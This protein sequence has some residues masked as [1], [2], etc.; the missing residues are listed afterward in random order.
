MKRLAA[1]AAPLA[2]AVCGT[3]HAQ[4]VLPGIVHRWAGDGDATDSEAG[5]NGTVVGAVSYGPGVCGQAFELTGGWIDFGNQAGN[6]GASDFTIA[7]L[8]RTTMLE[9]AAIMEKR[10]LICGVPSGTLDIH[11]TGDAQVVSAILGQA[12]GGASLSVNGLTAISDGL[13]HHVVVRRGGTVLQAIVDGV[14]DG[15]GESQLSYVVNNAGP[16]RI[17][18]SE[19]SDF[20]GMMPFIGQMDEI[21]FYLRALSDQEIESL[22]VIPCSADLDENN[23]VGVSDLLILLAFWGN[24][25][26]VCLG[27][28]DH[29]GQVGIADLLALLG[30]WGPCQ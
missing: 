28:V 23:S 15:A 13:W 19:C 2:L 4:L 25:G 16:L 11:K 22:A 26:P 24:C 18:R 17:G 21:Q 10:P 29:D 14:F 9:G 12:E 1:A 27:D 20:D 3:A 5:A 8:V 7:F 6:F 30:D